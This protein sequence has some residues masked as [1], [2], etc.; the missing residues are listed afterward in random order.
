MNSSE[1][2]QRINASSRLVGPKKRERIFAYLS[3]LE[4]HG[5]TAAAEELAATDS[6]YLAEYLAQYLELVPGY[7]AEKSR[8]AEA[9][10]EHGELV[11]AAAR[12]VPWLPEKT[13]QGF[14]DDYVSTGDPDAPVANV[15]YTIGIYRPEL[16]RPVADRIPDDSMRQSMLSGAPDSEVQRLLGEWEADKN[17]YH[18]VR[19][20]FTRTPLAQEALL[21]VRDEFDGSPEWETLLELSGALPDSPL[22]AGCSP[23]Y[24]GFV[25]ERGTGPHQVARPVSGDV[26]VCHLCETPAGHLLTLSAEDLPYGLTAD[27]TFYWYACGCDGT[28]S[29]TVR[30]DQGRT[31]VYY[32]PQGPA[33]PDFSFAGG[34]RS[35]VLEPHPNQVGVTTRGVTEQSLHQVGGLPRWIRPDIHPRCPECSKVMRF[36]AFMDSARTPF[37]QLRLGGI[38]YCFWCDGCRVSS[39]KIQY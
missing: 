14:I 11:G 29:T 18:L 16:L 3:T 36:L 28:E 34:E 33:D 35:L 20:A 4:E 22:S 10:R 8:A 6:R 26:P 15:L 13:L 5:A 30:N 32:G 19:L 39:T 2:I 23:A 38:V 21:G 12:L 37:G 24:M 7:A 1:E 25:A 27:P 17:P 9:L 31:T